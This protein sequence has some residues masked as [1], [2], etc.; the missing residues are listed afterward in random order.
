[1]S[2][3]NRFNLEAMVTKAVN[4]YESDSF[5]AEFSKITPKEARNVTR[6]FVRRMLGGGDV[7]RPA[8]GDNALGYMNVDGAQI[9]EVLEWL[10]EGELK[11]GKDY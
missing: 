10:R 7:N 9:G 2:N 4:E 5:S 3:D 11:R 6:F 1:M 8:S